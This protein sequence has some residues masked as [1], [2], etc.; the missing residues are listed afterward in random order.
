[1]TCICPAPS[2]ATCKYF[3]HGGGGGGGYENLNA[4]IS[5]LAAYYAFNAQYPRGTT[6]HS[7]NIFV[8]LEHILVS[9]QKAAVPVNVEHFL[10]M[11]K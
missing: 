2:Y 4:V 6:G 7:K 10:S 8:F 5:L 9:E 3:A 11:M 1:M